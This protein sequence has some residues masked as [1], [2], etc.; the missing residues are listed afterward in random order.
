[1]LRGVDVERNVTAAIKSRQRRLYPEPP[2]PSECEARLGKPDHDVAMRVPQQR[3]GARDGQRKQ[4]AVIDQI[5]VL[6]AAVDVPVGQ[7]PGRDVREP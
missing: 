1:L 4:W 6:E 5:G 2:Q 7:Q 3:C